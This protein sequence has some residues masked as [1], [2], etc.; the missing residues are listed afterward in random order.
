MAAVNVPSFSSTR[1]DPSAKFNWATNGQRQRDTMGDGTILA[2]A[3]KI[4]DG[5]CAV[6]AV[7]EECNK[8]TTSLLRRHQKAKK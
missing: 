8:I 1:L 5:E 2:A 4:E 7:H 6:G 3:T